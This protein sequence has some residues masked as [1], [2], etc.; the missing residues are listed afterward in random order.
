MNTLY[1]GFDPNQQE[2][3]EYDP[4]H[5]SNVYSRRRDENGQGDAVDSDTEQPEGIEPPQPE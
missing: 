2:H 5:G 1:V 3:P 4:H